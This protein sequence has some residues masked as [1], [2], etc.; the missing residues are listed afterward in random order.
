MDEKQIK[1]LDAKSTCAKIVDFINKSDKHKPR[2]CSTSSIEPQNPQRPSGELT[3]EAAID[4][5][6]SLDRYQETIKKLEASIKYLMKEIDKLKLD[7]RS[8][9]GRNLKDGIV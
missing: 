4:L 3:F 9:K 7:V 2:S 8:S 5:L 6:N 1:E